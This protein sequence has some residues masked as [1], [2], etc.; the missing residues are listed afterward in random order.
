MARANL[1]QLILAGN[2]TA[3]PEIRSLGRA[4]AFV[5][6]FTVAYHER[7]KPE[8]AKDPIETTDFF[9]CEAFGKTGEFLG[10]YGVKGRSVLLTGKARQSRWE[11]KDG[12][13]RSRITFVIT[14]AQF[15]DSN[16]AAAGGQG[17]GETA[18]A[19]AAEAEA[20]TGTEAPF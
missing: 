7:Y 8:G 10:R 11:D 1:N 20:S 5:T 9:D 14:R 4:D 18:A 16:P 12:N 15:L 2:L 3:D 17:A 13:K 19:A 6:A